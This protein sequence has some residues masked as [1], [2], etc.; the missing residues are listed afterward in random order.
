VAR[1][2]PCVLD[3]LRAA[4]D[5]PIPEPDQIDDRHVRKAVSDL[6]DGDDR[7]RL[8]GRL[9]PPDRIDAHPEE[10]PI[11][12]DREASNGAALGNQRGFARCRNNTSP[13]IAMA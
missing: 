9:E 13:P 3:A 11:A 8:H 4:R 6:P 5:V 12:E 2:N 10:L 7:E 1:E